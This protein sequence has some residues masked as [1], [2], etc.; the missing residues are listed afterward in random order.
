ME[1]VII[2]PMTLSGKPWK[3]CAWDVP[4]PLQNIIKPG[5]TVLIKPNL[6]DSLPGVL[7]P[8][9]VVELAVIDMAVAAGAARICIAD[10]GINFMETKQT[11]EAT[12]YAEMARC[13]QRQYPP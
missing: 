5:N 3:G 8:P 7:Y 11:L 4:Q 9:E 13:L 12:H 6:I 10:A 2:L 1:A